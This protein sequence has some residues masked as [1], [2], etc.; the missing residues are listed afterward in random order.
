[1]DD[2]RF[3]AIARAVSAAASRRQAPRLLAAAG[4]AAWFPRRASAADGTC[5]PGLTFCKNVGACVDLATDLNN[6]GACGAICQ[7]DLVPVRCRNGVCERANCPPELAYCGA[8]DGC[9]DL[10]TDPLHCGACQNPCASGVCSGGVCVGGAG[11]A[12][13]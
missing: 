1:M 2:Q 6:C 4:L 11:C 3:D 12:P 7:S 9:R 13:G 10:L 5:D 8:V